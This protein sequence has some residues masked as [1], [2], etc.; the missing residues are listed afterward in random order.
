MRS[1][2]TR[3]G[4]AQHLVPREVGPRGLRGL[5]HESMDA[6][7]E[8]RH[9]AQSQ[10]H[11]TGQHKCRADAAHQLH[12]LWLHVAHQCPRRRNPQ[13]GR[14]GRGAVEVQPSRGGRAASRGKRI[15]ETGS[16]QG[17]HGEQQGSALAPNVTPPTHEE[18]LSVKREPPAIAMTDE[19]YKYIQTLI[20]RELKGRIESSA[21]FALALAALSVAATVAVTVAATSIPE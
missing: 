11:R 1:F 17:E 4:Q 16:S 6:A 12:E 3:S 8:A 18:L 21:W 9:G 10:P 2:G 13:R 20:K 5:R 19:H 14:L 15:A 7:S